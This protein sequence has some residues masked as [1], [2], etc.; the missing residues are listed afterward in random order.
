LGFNAR[1]RK[2]FHNAVMRYSM[3]PQVYFNWWFF[4]VFQRFLSL[5]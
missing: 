5:N 3:P 2:A 4:N 1:Q